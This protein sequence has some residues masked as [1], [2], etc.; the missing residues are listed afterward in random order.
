MEE[1]TVDLPGI[2]QFR[3]DSQVAIVTGGGKGLGLAMAA[4]LASA[5]ANIL[6]VGRDIEIAQLRAEELIKKFGVDA[7][8]VEGDVVSLNAMQA[9][10]AAAIERWGK[11]SILINS[12]GI[13]IR[14][15]IDMMAPDDFEQVMRT[16]VSGTWNAC[17][18]VLPSMKRAR[19]G[20][21]VN[22][23]STLGT[24]GL[25]NRTAY[26]SSKG[27]VVQMTR[28]LALEVASHGITCN[29]IC[30]GPFLTE[31]NRSIVGTEEANRFILGAVALD[32]WGQLEE[33]QGA[34]IYLSSRASSY[35]TGS[36]LTVDGGW[37]AR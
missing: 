27:A 23:A 37:T 16:N 9:V 4:G 29:A 31:I 7:I 32:R 33:I 12:A 28:A 14:G 6:L 24:V 13:N 10:A 17:R 25:A 1:A 30:P 21:I 2:S 3:M 5:G 34:A 36:L 18:A 15:S 26:A 8:A 20:R 35:T 11:I 19:Y 22:M